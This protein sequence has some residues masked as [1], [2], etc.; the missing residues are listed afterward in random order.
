[1]PGTPENFGEGYYYCGWLLI[2]LLNSMDLPFAFGRDSFW[3]TRKPDNVSPV[4]RFLARLPA[5]RSAA[6]AIQRQTSFC[7]AILCCLCWDGV[8]PGRFPPCELAKTRRQ[9]AVCS[10]AWSQSNAVF[11]FEL[12]SDFCLSEDARSLFIGF[13]PA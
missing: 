13:I 12:R 7:P 2:A 11:S 5:N 9:E 6:V 10:T 4:G 8:G 3:A 1:M